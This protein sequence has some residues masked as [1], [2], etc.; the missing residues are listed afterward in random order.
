MSRKR[1]LP[2]SGPHEP[3]ILSSVFNTKVYSHPA[4]LSRWIRHDDLTHLGLHFVVTP[5]TCGER[6]Y[7]F[8]N[9]LQSNVIA[10]WLYNRCE[11]VT[12]LQTQTQE[13]VSD[14]VC[15]SILDAYVTS[16]GVIWVCDA[17]LLNNEIV[18]KYS[19]LIRME[20]LREFFRSWRGIG[21]RMNA[22][23]MGN[24]C[25]TALENIPC[26][27]VSDRYLMVKPNYPL[28]HLLDIPDMMEVDGFIF[29]RL[30][31]AYGPY[32]SI[33]NASLKWSPY[34][35]VKFHVSVIKQDVKNGMKTEKTEKVKN[36]A[37]DLYPFYTVDTLSNRY[38]L[39]VQVGDELVHVASTS[40][41]DKICLHAR[42]EFIGEFIW[43]DLWQC[44][45][46][47]EDRKAPNT[48]DVFLETLHAISHPVTMQQIRDA[49]GL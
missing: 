21:E 33:P 14:E 39:K 18:N 5:R 22:F 1:S 9:K 27:S 42:S 49:I 6:V 35:S 24:I 31:T 26:V 2:S 43:N 23:P 32:R 15:M 48:M 8:L 7:V 4:M 28:G 41:V 19:V 29:S 45:R 10:I 13:T 3:E 25:S 36:E 34:P 47:R 46:I 37:M 16:D 30:M 44:V 17:L 40:E 20:K 11:E 12:R 38:K